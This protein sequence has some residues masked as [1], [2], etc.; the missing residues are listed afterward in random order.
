MFVDVHAHLSYKPLISDISNVVF[1]AKKAGLKYII[2]NGT[3]FESN[4]KVLEF[5]KKFDIVKASLG[6]FPDYI[7]KYGYDNFLKEFSW[8][9]KQKNIFALGEIGLDNATYKDDKDMLKGFKELVSFGI[10]KKIPMIIHSRKAEREVVSVLEDLGAKKVVLHF[11]SGK[12][13]LVRKG[14]D[15]GWSFSIPTNVVRSAQLQS[16][17]RL[18]PITQLFSETDCPWLSPFN[19]GFNEPAFVVEGVKKIASIKEMDFE[20][21][22]KNIFMNF[23]RMFLK[24]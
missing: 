5:A 8:I 17:V 13:S 12:K 4:R 3:E 22:Q 14:I 21:V 2:S 16:N 24:I 10:R 9:T 19:K 23:Q 15:N 20:E 6:Y 7:V 11:F 1:R 18:I